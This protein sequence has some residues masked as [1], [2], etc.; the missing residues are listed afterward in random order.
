MVNAFLEVLTIIDRIKEEAEIEYEDARYNHMPHDEFAV[1]YRT[2][3]MLSMLIRD[4]GERLAPKELVDINGSER[5]VDAEIAKEI[6]DLRKIERAARDICT[7]AE[8][9][10]TAAQAC[11]CLSA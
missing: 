8:R 4:A 2:C 1:K 10:S 9:A 7:A 5:A 6:R 11:A 3:S